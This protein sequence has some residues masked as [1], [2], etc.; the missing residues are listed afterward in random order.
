MDRRFSFES[1]QATFEIYRINKIGNQSSAK[2]YNL[3]AIY[4]IFLLSK[5][6]SNKLQGRGEH[7]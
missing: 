3:L 1:I 2:Y 5:I 7:I 6:K 4:I